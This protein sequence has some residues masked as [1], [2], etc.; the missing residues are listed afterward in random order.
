MALKTILIG[1]YKPT[2][3][4]FFGAPQLIDAQG[5]HVPDVWTVDVEL[6]TVWQGTKKEVDSQARFFAP[7]LVD[8]YDEFGDSII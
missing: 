2:K 4:R 8:W 6:P 1:L 7:L 3:I 5:I